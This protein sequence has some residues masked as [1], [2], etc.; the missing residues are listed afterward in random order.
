VITHANALLASA[1][2]GSCDYV[3]GDVRDVDSVLAGA[4]RTLDLTRPVAVL[5]LQLLHFFPEQDNPYALVQRVM[6]AMSPGSFLVLVHGPSDVDLQAAA[7]LTKMS[8]ASPVP[9]RLRSREEVSRFFDGL[10]LIDPGLVSGTEWL[11]AG[12]AASAENPG[13]SVTYGYTGVARKP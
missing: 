8:Q 12:R 4:A 11:R 13:A 5:M 10:E 7:E 1:P 2:E 3:Q 6:S 9:L